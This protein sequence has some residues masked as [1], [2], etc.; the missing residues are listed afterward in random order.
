MLSHAEDVR[1]VS[2]SS[3]PQVLPTAAR[4]NV[5]SARASGNPPEQTWRQA[6]RR[7]TAMLTSP[8]NVTAAAA[9]ESVLG[10]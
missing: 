6:F 1:R 9:I 3:L 5:L 8:I 7:R 4:R 2:R 10:C